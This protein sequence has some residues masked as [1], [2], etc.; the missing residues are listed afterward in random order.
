MTYCESPV[1]IQNT[2]INHVQDIEEDEW[3]HIPGTD[4]VLFVDPITLSVTVRPR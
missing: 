1:G 3:N 2:G 4:Q